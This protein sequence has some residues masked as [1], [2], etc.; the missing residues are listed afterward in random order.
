MVKHDCDA[1]GDEGVNSN[2]YNDTYLSQKQSEALRRVSRPRL[3]MLNLCHHA[4]AFSHSLL[5]VHLDRRLLHS[6]F[7]AMIGMV[8]RS[9]RSSRSG[10][11]KLQRKR[12]ARR[13]ETGVLSLNTSSYRQGSERI[14]D[15][16]SLLSRL[17]LLDGK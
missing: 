10:L 17:E 6:L 5:V 3:G 7:V 12:M 11:G 14:L 8:R 13:V 1:V 4:Q 15:C 9:W 2:G 16:S